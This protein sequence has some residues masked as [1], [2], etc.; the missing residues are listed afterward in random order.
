[1]VERHGY[2]IWPSPWSRRRTLRGVRLDR[3][4]LADLR[5][6]LRS[7]PIVAFL[8]LELGAGAV[9][10][11]RRGPDTISTVVLIWLGM[12]VVAFLAWWA[13]RHRLAHP[14][15]DPV[16][17]ARARTA[18]ALIGVAGMLIWSASANAVGVVLVACGIGG[19]LWAA[20]RSGGLNGLGEQLT[21]S[22]RPFV[23]LLLFIAL[24]RLVVGG[25]AYLGGAVLALPSGIG[26]QL[27]YLVGL[28]GPLEAV[29]RRS[30]AAVVCALIFGL[31][32]V[33]FVL[34]AN[35]GDVVAAF[36]NAV[37]FQASVG[38]VA[39]LAYQRHRAVLPIGVAHALAIG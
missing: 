36:A 14:R 2:R 22:P 8:V 31:L 39:C 29:G 1:M 30:A 19:W 6:A 21:R 10:V 9:F 35:H 23:P 18:F 32:H 38:I 12:S 28:Y 25:P 3:A 11:W 7:G 37:L 34:E 24:P 33:P 13:G 5:T 20:W 26:Q 15:P 17:A 16:P 4:L 27:L